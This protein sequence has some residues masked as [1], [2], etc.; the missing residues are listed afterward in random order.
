M[1]AHSHRYPNMDKRRV[2]AQWFDCL[3]G[4]AKPL[5][6]LSIYLTIN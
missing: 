4:A 5:R 3:R 2:A 1:A 6:F